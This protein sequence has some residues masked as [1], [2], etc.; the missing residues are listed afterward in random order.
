[1]Q[2]H[3]DNLKVTNGELNETLK[4]TLQQIADLTAE[5]EKLKDQLAMRVGK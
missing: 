2:I 3:N 4:I 5:N 1:L